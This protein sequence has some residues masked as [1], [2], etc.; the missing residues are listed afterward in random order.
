[1]L[2]ERH[3]LRFGACSM[4]A[5]GQRGT[6]GWPN[7]PRLSLWHEHVARWVIQNK[8]AIMEHHA[9]RI[10]VVDDEAAIRFTLATVLRRQG[11][12]VTTAANSVEAWD[13]L[14]QEPFDL[15]LVDLKL[16]GGMSGLEI[17]ER[18]R[19]DQ[20]DTAILILTGSAEAVEGLAEISPNNFDCMGKTA[21]P[22]DVLD[23]VAALL[24]W[25]PRLY[26]RTRNADQERTPIFP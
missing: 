9:A 17:A 25:E 20:P 18:A 21:S 22:Q 15:L 14:C 8:G 19:A 4:P 1:M 6:N 13:L 10:L 16:P 7:D 3:H 12:A 23:R 2:R 11:Y 26:E 5:Y 24:A